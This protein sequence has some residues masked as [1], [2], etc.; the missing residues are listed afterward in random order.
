MSNLTDAL[1]LTGTRRNIA[2][3]RNLP[4]D[5]AAQRVFD[6]GWVAGVDFDE[7]DFARPGDEVR[8]YAILPHEDE[9]RVAVLID[10]TR[11]A[12][13]ATPA[14]WPPDWL[15]LT[16]QRMVA[17]ASNEADRRQVVEQ[18]EARAGASYAEALENISATKREQWEAAGEGAWA[19]VAATS[20]V[21]GTQVG[22][23][24][25][26]VTSVVGKVAGQTAAGLLRGLGPWFTVGIAAVAVGAVGFGIYRA[27]R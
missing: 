22:R 24:A 25:G 13:G 26:A 14:Y 3:A 7:V 18:L 8:V 2:G 1:G 16:A 21:V 17:L 6:P 23:V 5:E 12:A 10:L 19:G 4:D 20:A 15:E 27:T 11:A 9:G